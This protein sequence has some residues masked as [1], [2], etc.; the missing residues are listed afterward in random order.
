VEDLFKI[1]RIINLLIRLGD[2][3]WHVS[4]Q[5]GRGEIENL[6]EGQLGFSLVSVGF[7]LKAEFDDAEGNHHHLRGES[8]IV[9]FRNRETIKLDGKDV[10]K[11]NVTVSPH[12]ADDNNTLE[13]AVVEFR[14]RHEGATHHYKFEKTIE[15]DDTEDD[16]DG[17][18]NG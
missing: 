12:F 4:H 7:L 5:E 10:D 2:D 9:N 13:R 11:D 17:E 15:G 8:K 3:G 1:L 18:D 14:F 6:G 16:E